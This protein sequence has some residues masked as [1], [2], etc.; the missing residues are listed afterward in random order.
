MKSGSATA[1][2]SN[3]GFDLGAGIE[4]FFTRRATLAGELLYHK[5][6]DVFAPPLIVQNGSFWTVARRSIL[7]LAP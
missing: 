5:V 1:D 6:G 7:S 2:D 3:P 4:S